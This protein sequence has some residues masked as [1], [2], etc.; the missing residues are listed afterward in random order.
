[1]FDIENI[2]KTKLTPDISFKLWLQSNQMV[3]SDKE[4][5]MDEEVDEDS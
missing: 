3:E 4:T 1:M 2:M 5:K